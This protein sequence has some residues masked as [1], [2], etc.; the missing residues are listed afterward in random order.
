[1]GRDRAHELEPERGPVVLVI[2]DQHRRE[3]D[4][5]NQRRCPR[6][7]TEQ[8]APPPVRHQRERQHRG[9]Q[10]DRGEFRQHRQAGEQPGGE[11]P[12]RIAAFVE[13]DQRPQH[14]DRERDHRRIGRHLRHQQP[15]IKRGLRHQQ[16]EHHGAEI[17]RDAADDIDEQQLRHQHRHDAAEPHAEIGVAENRS[18]EPDQ[19]GDA[20]A[21]GRGRPARSPSTRSSN[22]PRR[23]AAR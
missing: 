18:A 9:Q 2:P 12:A 19:P 15:V 5:C 6:I 17:M 7:G 11:P 23:C 20:R 13:P 14:R 8:P 22:R 10:H 21:D 3:H 16:R 1:M 4:Q